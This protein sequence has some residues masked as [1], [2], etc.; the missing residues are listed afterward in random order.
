MVAMPLLD[1]I[2]AV[3]WLGGLTLFLLGQAVLGWLRL[4]YAR[5]CARHA[6]RLS[7]A[8]LA[9]AQER[10]VRGPH[11]EARPDSVSPTQPTH[12]H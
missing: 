9:I 7:Q 11:P 4:R 8:T 3:I 2:I 6:S 12:R 1:L 10:A 5:R